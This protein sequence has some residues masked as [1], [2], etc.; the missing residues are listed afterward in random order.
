MKHLNTTAKM[1]NIFS[2]FASNAL[3]AI[4]FCLISYGAQAQE[5][6]SL[7]LRQMDSIQQLFQIE[8]ITVIASLPKTRM[9]GDAICTR[10]AGSVLEQAGT[11]EDV[12]SK[13]PGIVV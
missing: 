11:A 8:E 2:I 6:D 9:K 12:L 1:G 5:I 3:L 7:L 10:V 13:V 4:L